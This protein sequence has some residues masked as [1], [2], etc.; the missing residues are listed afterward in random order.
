MNNQPSQ[1]E[2]GSAHATIQGLFHMSQSQYGEAIPHFDKAIEI[3][4][5]NWTAL[6]ARAFCKSMLFSNVPNAHKPQHLSEI[7]SDL[8]DSIKFL[9]ETKD[10]MT[11]TKS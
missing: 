4:P 10:I 5:N 9:T 3:T 11:A 6:Q 1:I 2:V 7:I 8:S